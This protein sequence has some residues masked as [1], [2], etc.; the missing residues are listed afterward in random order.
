M[1]QSAGDL[2]LQPI[3]AMSLSELIDEVRGELRISQ[4]ELAARL[5]LSEDQLYRRKKQE[6]RMPRT[7]TTQLRMMLMQSRR[8]PGHASRQ[9]GESPVQSGSVTIIPRDPVLAAAARPAPADEPD[10]QQFQIEMKPSPVESAMQELEAAIIGGRFGHAESRAKVSGLSQ[11][12][13][14]VSEEYPLATA[15]GSG[16]DFSSLCQALRDFGLYLPENCDGL[17]RA[18]RHQVETIF[19]EYLRSLDACLEWVDEILGQ[20]APQEVVAM[21]AGLRADIE[22]LAIA[23]MDLHSIYDDNVDRSRYDARSREAKQAMMPRLK[24]LLDGHIQAGAAIMR[25]PYR[26]VEATTDQLSMEVRNARGEDRLRVQDSFPLPYRMILNE[27]T[28]LRREMDDL[29]SIRQRNA[30]G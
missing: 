3:L 7:L 13:D 30:T 6:V 9:S 24:A 23:R 20:G 8:A 2:Q 17:S 29:R 18:E 12:F 11:L 27:L 10:V 16:R 15:A 21:I 14:K 22:T 28:A 1:S 19:R 5:G 25:N 4:K 26:L